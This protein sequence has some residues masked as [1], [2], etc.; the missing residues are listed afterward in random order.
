MSSSVCTPDII[1]TT[2]A[3]RRRAPNSPTLQAT[4]WLDFLFSVSINAWMRRAQ[5]AACSTCGMGREGEKAGV[6]A[7]HAPGISYLKFSHRNLPRSASEDAPRLT[8]GDARRARTH[9]LVRDEATIQVYQIVSKGEFGHFN[10]SGQLCAHGGM[11]RT[12]VTPQLAPRIRARNRSYRTPRWL[13]EK[14]VTFALRGGGRWLAPGVPDGSADY[15]VWCSRAFSPAPARARQEVQVVPHLSGWNSQ[16]RLQR[17]W[18]LQGWGLH[19]SYS[20]EDICLFL[21]HPASAKRNSCASF[22]RASWISA[23]VGTR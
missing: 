8:F 4:S 19:R 20:E 21:V 18:L 12:R 23:N 22:I 17:V 2:C 16:R 3:Q 6:S 15:P 14:E 11:P 10:L 13:K 7:H 1:L 9:S 5:E